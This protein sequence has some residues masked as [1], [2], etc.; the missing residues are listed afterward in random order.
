MRI[1]AQA[2]DIAWWSCVAEPAD[3]HAVALISA[4]GPT[5][6]RAW[7]QAPLPGA[8]PHALEGQG[9]WEEAHAR[10]A[11]R[12]KA[13]GVQAE[14]EQLEELGG[15]FIVPG[16]AQW[17]ESLNDLGPLRPLGLWTIGTL[18]NNPRVSIVGA[19]AASSAG[20]RNAFDLG[21]GLAQVGVSTCSG[22]AFGIDIA[23][24]RGCRAASAPTIAVMAGSLSKPYPLAHEEDFARIIAEG[25]ALI[26]ECPSSWRP[27]KWRFL[28]RNRIIAALSP[29]TVVVEASI[30]SGALATARR[31]MELGREVGAMPGPLSSSSSEGCH[32]LIRNSATL[33]RDA[34]DV[35]E[36][37]EPF[38]L[39]GQGTLFGAPVMRDR[40][41]DALNPIPRRVFEAL[42]KRSFARLSRLSRAAGLS[43]SEV[44]TALAEL[45]LAGLIVS[46][47]QG[48]ARRRA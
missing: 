48:W 6:A 1:E 45:E 14:L 27:A 7:A 15:R 46:D 35:L 32:E 23:A 18:P 21:A 5:E 26:S 17:P 42:P 12:A 8:L 20:E 25:G 36:L 34:Q 10:W 24:H 47:S 4:L 19:R 39:G 2:F 28:S 13:P 40:G 43:E 9:R 31:A 11:P 33:I 29:V 41:V 38:T 16:D 30:R 22:G 37:L 3:P 44:L